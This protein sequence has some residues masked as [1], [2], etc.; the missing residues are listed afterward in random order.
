MRVSCKHP[1]IRTGRKLSRK[2][3][4][5]LS[6]RSWSSTFYL[7]KCISEWHGMPYF[8]SICLSVF[9]SVRPSVRPTDRPAVH[10]P[11]GPPTHPSINPSI[12]PSA[13]YARIIRLC[14]LQTILNQCR[15]CKLL[16]LMSCYLCRNDILSHYNINILHS[17]LDQTV[18]MRIILFHLS[19]DQPIYFFNKQDWRFA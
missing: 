10:P 7:I 13:Q 4:R 14:R 5:P 16:M 9:L 18:V 12:H 17:Q 8:S 3:T 11:A 1:Q 19:R 2:W 6:S 15:G